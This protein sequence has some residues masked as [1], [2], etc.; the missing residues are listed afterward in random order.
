MKET[1]CL[2]TDSF[3]IF[4]VKGFKYP[5]TLFP[6]YNSNTKV[7]R[8]MRQI[9]FKLNFP[10]VWLFFGKRKKELKYIKKI[11]LIETSHY[12]EIFRYIKKIN[13][14]IVLYFYYWNPSCRSKIKIHEVERFAK[15][16]TFDYLDSRENNIYFN[17][18]FFFPNMYSERHQTNNRNILFI[19]ADKEGRFNILCNL[20]NIFEKYGIS[21]R[22]YLYSLDRSKKSNTWLTILRKPFSYED[23]LKITKKFDYILEILDSRQSTMTLR[24]LEAL[25]M[26]KKLVTNN[27][28][29]MNEKIYN[30]N[31]IFVFQSL[32]DF[33][34]D[35][36][37]KFAHNDFLADKEIEFYSYE[38]WLRRFL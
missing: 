7:S 19:G 32:S 34:S 28:L 30:E 29:L 14:K 37:Y 3:G 18:N 33:S 16:Y 13:P 11:I 25:A 9:L 12:K 8:I 31:N 27:I 1:I 22:V 17:T 6:V 4:N 35:K 20:N 38:K 10:F 24:T 36:F 5:D 23:Y 21:L 2:Y 26:N 15:V